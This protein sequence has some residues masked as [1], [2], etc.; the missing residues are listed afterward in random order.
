VSYGPPLLHLISVLYAQGYEFQRPKKAVVSMGFVRH[1]N[2]R[3]SPRSQLECRTSITK[4]TY[5]KC[6][7]PGDEEDWILEVESVVDVVVVDNDCRG[8][9]D[10]DRDDDY[11]RKLWFLGLGR[12]RDGQRRGHVLFGG[13][14]DHNLLILVV[15]HR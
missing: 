11:C 15:L 6:E 1:G 14:G 3:R 7:M 13:Q 12:H 4:G 2:G 9:N 8:E 10:P 5:S